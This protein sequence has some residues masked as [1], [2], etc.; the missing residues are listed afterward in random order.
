MLNVGN[1][2]IY[3]GNLDL[4]LENRMAAYDFFLYVTNFALRH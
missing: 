2:R 3:S 4:M 1:Y